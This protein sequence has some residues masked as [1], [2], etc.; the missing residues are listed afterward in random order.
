MRM[1]FI[2]FLQ[3]LSKGGPRCLLGLPCGPVVE[4]LGLVMKKRR[5]IYVEVLKALE[6]LSKSNIYVVTPL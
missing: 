4:G 6:Y 1:S 2:L 3:F 5:V